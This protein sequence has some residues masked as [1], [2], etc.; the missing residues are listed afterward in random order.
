MNPIINKA[1]RDI[2]SVGVAPQAKFRVRR[3]VLEAITQAR[4]EE[5][6]RLKDKIEVLVSPV[7]EPERDVYH[8]MTGYQ[9]ALHDILSLLKAEKEK[10]FKGLI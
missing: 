4:E 2:T 3:I 1:V 5:R 6:I 9:N 8:E 7:I 10:K